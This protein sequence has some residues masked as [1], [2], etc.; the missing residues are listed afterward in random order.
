MYRANARLLVRPQLAFG[1]DANVD[2]SF[3]KNAAE[4]GMA[5]VDAGKLAQ[6]KGSSP[7][8]KEFGAMAVTDHSAANA[9]LRSIAAAQGVKLTTSASVMQ[10]A[11]QKELQMSSGDSFDKS[12]IKDQIKAHADTMDLFKK[13]IAS[14]KDQ[15]ARDFSSSTLP[16]VQAQPVRIKQIAAAAGIAAG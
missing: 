10:M 1:M 8:V 4:G 5:E 14:A 9:K 16:T 6:Q 2:S 13:E 12:Y 7:A 15:Q 11:S 3:F